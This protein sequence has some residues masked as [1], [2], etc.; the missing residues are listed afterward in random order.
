[1]SEWRAYLRFHAIDAAAPYLSPPFERNAFAFYQRTLEGQPQ[2]RPRWQRVLGALNDAMG[3]AL[4]RLYVAQYFP[5][6]AKAR[7]ETLTA[8]I[9]RALEMR[10]ERLAWMSAATK[11]KALQKLGM[12]VTKIGYPDPDEW[13]S[14]KGLKIVPHDYFANVEAA[15]RFNYHWQ[16]D[17]IG[18]KTDRREWEMTP[19]T[20]NAYYDPLTNSI[21]FPAGILQPPFF[22]ANGDD[23][24]N[25]GAIGAVIGH[26]SSHAFDDQGS[27]F[28]GEGD[29][30]NWWT[31]RDR[32]RF[33]ARTKRL[34][35]QFDAYAPIKG[36]PR[37][38]VNGR[39]TLGENIADLGG[40]NIAY[41]AL[42]SV[43]AKNPALASQRIQ[44]FTEDQRFFLAFARMWRGSEREKTA[45]LM[46][47]VDPHAPPRI[48]AIAAPSN[49]PQFADAFE[50]RA[51]E[52]M[53]RPA[54]KRV[55]IW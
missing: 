34:V 42:Q 29:R 16:I 23:A 32:A 48:R 9:H 37:L 55:K 40:I 53:V 45:E 12:F 11:A 24:L 8:N 50:C 4:G 18:K 14:W 5:P 22:Y 27:Q 30:V 17:K 28:N 35:E 31:A 38:H 25:Y 44:G 51:G 3:M 2:M 46:L 7:A 20:I 41:D 21:N 13:R 43:L 39:L 6:S 15:S 47:N 52:A 36:H 54:S 1:M 10:I 26:E 33:D 49:M 19:Q